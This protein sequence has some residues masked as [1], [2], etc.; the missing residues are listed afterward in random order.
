MA[1]EINQL[2]DEKEAEIILDQIKNSS[3]KTY[4][5]T[6]LDESERN[7]YLSK[8]LGQKVLIA[9]AIMD[10][11]Y[12]GTSYDIIDPLISGNRDIEL[13]ISRHRMINSIGKILV[14]N[15]ELSQM[16]AGKKGY[17]EWREN[18]LKLINRLYRYTNGY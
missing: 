2:F 1:I 16:M 18:I 13:N 3:I 6:V 5:L 15:S 12:N 10:A 7:A 4:I 11:L 8:D 9:A 14:S 17:S